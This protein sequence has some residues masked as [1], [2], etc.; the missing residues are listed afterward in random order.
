[1]T[2][3]IL[4]LLSIVSS[5]SCDVFHIGSRYGRLSIYYAR[6]YN[7]EWTFKDEDRFCKSI[8][9]SLPTIHSYEDRTEL[10]S[11]GYNYI[12]LNMKVVNESNHWKTVWMDGS[13]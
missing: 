9:S 10:Q 4:I 6:P 12:G 2:I 5:I 1:M 7:S 11:L 13:K 3:S 8:K